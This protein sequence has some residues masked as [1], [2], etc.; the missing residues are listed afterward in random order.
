MDIN[1]TPENAEKTKKFYCKKCDFGCSKQ[2]DYDRHISTQKHKTHTKDINDIEK[3]PKNTENNTC[4]CGKIYKNYSS[5]WRHKKT[6]I[7][8]NNTENNDNFQKNVNEKSE[9]I[10]LLLHLLTFQTPN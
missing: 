7:E 5:L 8:I 10:D 9:V 2:S 1:F 6:C 3:P 4:S